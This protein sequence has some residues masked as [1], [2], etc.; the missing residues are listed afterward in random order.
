MIFKRIKSGL[1]F[2]APFSTFCIVNAVADILGPLGGHFDM[3]LTTVS[4]SSKVMSIF[5]N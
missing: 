3:R 1:I 5:K 2:K 4:L